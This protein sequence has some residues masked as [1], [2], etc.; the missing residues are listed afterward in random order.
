M[1]F[2]NLVNM[3][4]TIP[5]IKFFLGGYFFG[6]PSRLNLIMVLLS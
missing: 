1:N 4:A 6:A 5:E 2:V 3:P